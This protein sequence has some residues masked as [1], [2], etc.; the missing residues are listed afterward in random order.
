MR[1]IA[2][3]SSP[4]PGGALGL[5]LGVGSELP[6]PCSSSCVVFTPAP[7]QLMGHEFFLADIALTRPTGL[8]LWVAG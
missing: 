7:A 2:G 4:T 8:G 3:D 6:V 5:P 1:G